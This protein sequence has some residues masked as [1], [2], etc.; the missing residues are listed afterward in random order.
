MRNIINI[1]IALLIFSCNPVKKVLNSPEK[2]DIVIE[3]VIRRGKC[4]NDTIVVTSF[5]D[6]VVYKDSIIEV[7]SRVPC[8]DFD[9]SYADGTKI[10]VVG[11][12]LKY[13]HSCKVKQTYRTKVVT[14]NIRDRAFESILMKDVSKR[15]SS[16]LQLEKSVRS[17]Q[18]ANKELSGEVTWWKI[19]F[20]FWVLAALVIIFRKPIIKIARGFI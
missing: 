8:A 13:S 12:V 19:R 15:D 20:W 4:I 9:T 10:A 16:I 7:I 6:S 17:L 1:C 5:K 11:G 14:N 3:E 2:F 18:N